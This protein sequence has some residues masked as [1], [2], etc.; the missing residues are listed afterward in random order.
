MQMNVQRRTAAAARARPAAFA[1]RALRVSAL[2]GGER[3]VAGSRVFQAPKYYQNSGLVDSLGDLVKEMFPYVSRPAIITW[4]RGSDDSERLV[5]SFPDGALVHEHR[6]ECTRQVVDDVLAMC[7]AAGIDHVVAFGGGKVIDVG[8]MVASGINAKTVV[9]PSVA[10]TDAPCTGLSVMYTPDGAFDEYVFFPKSPDLVVVDTQ[11]LFNSPLRFTVAGI[12]D[13]MATYYE[14][15][16]VMRNP[17]GVTLINPFVFRPTLLSIAVAHQC[18][19]TLYEH[20]E[21]ALDAK[22][23]GGPLNKSFE[24]V[25][26]ANILMSGIGAESG[27][28]AAAHAIHNALVQFPESHNML[29][30]EKV[31]FGTIAQLIMEGDEEEALRVFKFN[32]MVGL[33]TSFKDLGIDITDEKLQM[34]AEHCLLPDSTMWNMGPHVTAEQIIHAMVK[35]ESL[36]MVLV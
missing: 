16:A 10:S 25:V 4:N 27:G 21:A 35:A 29:H 11:V 20:C 3:P 15:R 13:A 18:A 8:K 1:R 12:G 33:P 14:A 36:T 17:N 30:G 22:K 7:K 34:V 5:N 6:G 32:K 2:N 26:E 31:A 23:S 19:E 9:V 28:L 24:D